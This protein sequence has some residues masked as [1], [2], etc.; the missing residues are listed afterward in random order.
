MDGLNSNEI[1]KKT[2]NDHKMNFF[3]LPVTIYGILREKL[4]NAQSGFL[5]DAPDS[6]WMN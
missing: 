5:L 1:K 3:E 6:D 4:Q 2:F